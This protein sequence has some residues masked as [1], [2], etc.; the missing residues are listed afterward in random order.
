MR[1]S[2]NNKQMRER[3]ECDQR[4]HFGLRKFSVGVASV[5]LSTTFFMSSGSH[6][7]KADTSVTPETANSSSSN[8]DDDLQKKAV[9]LSSSSTDQASDSSSATQTSDATSTTASDTQKSAATSETATSD[10]QSS[11]S[12]TDTTTES[13]QKSDASSSSTAVS[14][15]QD[16]DAQKQ[17]A[18]VADG[19]AD[20][21]VKA[22]NANT[23]ATETLNTTKLDVQ[24]SGE[25][26]LATGV[27]VNLAATNDSSNVMGWSYSV[28]GSTVT[29]NSYSGDK[30]NVVIPTASDFRKAGVSSAASVNIS[31]SVMKSVVRAGAVSISISNTTSSEKVTASDADWSDALSTGSVTEGNNTLKT[32]DLNRLDT[33]NIT[34]MRYMFRRDVALTTLNIS[35]WNTANVTN[36]RSMFSFAG[37]YG[38]LKSIDVSGWNTGNVTDMYGMFY[39]ART[40]TNLDVSR[41]NTSKVTDMSWMFND[42]WSLTTL[43]VSKWDTRNVTDMSYMFQNDKLLT[44]LDVSNW[45]TSKVT[46]MTSMFSKMSSLTSLNVSGWNTANVT[47][48]FS[49][50]GGMSSLTSLDVSKWDTRNV[51]NMSYLFQG[52]K[53]LTTL[54]VS[55]WN[56]ANV[57][58][59]SSMFQY[60]SSLTSFDVSRWDTGKV[61]DM[62][63]VF[64]GMSS[65]T[66]LNVSGWNTSNVTNMRQMF[67][68]MSS[69][70]SLNVS[71]WNT[72]NVTNMSSMF[73]GDKSLTTLDVSKWYTGKVADMSWMFADAS[74]LTSLDVSGWNTSNVTNMSRVFSGMSSLTSLNVSGWKTGNVTNMSG[75][76]FG[77]TSLSE[78]SVKNWNTINVTDMSWM[79]SGASALTTLDVSDWLVNNVTSMYQMFG[80]TKSLKFLD[81]R[82]WNN[83]KL[84]DSKRY[85][86]AIT[87]SGVQTVFANGSQFDPTMLGMDAPSPVLIIV[88]NDTQKAAISRSFYDVSATVNGANTSRI[89]TPQIL[90]TAQ[91]TSQV[92]TDKQTVSDYLANN[93]NGAAY[94]LVNGYYTSMNLASVPTT[95]EATNLGPSAQALHVL[96]GL[97]KL[98]GSNGKQLNSIT[99]AG[100]YTTPLQVVTGTYNAQAVV[101]D[102]TFTVGNDG[103]I[104][105]NSYVGSGMDVKI[106]TLDDFKKAN[107]NGINDSSTVS[108]SAS[109]MKSLVTNGATSIKISDT[110]PNQKVVASGDNW[111]LALSSSN[112]VPV[113]YNSTLKSV[114]LSRLDTSNV[115]S[116]YK[117]FAYDNALTDV[118][119]SGWDTSKVTDFSGMFRYD[120]ALTNITGIE[121]I[122]TSSVKSMIGMFAGTSL[123]SLDLHK[124]NTS[125]VTFMLEM[126]AEMSNLSTLNLAGWNLSNV[127]A[128][129]YMFQRDTSL[130]SLDLSNWNLSSLSDANGMFEGMTN[131][132]SLKL[133]GWDFSNLIKASSN[134]TPAET[135]NS[136][137][138]EGGLTSLTDLSLSGAKFGLT[139]YRNLFAPAFSGLSALKNLDLSNL[140]DQVTDLHYAFYNEGS[141]TGMKL[142][143][144]NV[145]DWD[146]TQVTD[147]EYAFEDLD[148]P[149][150]DVSTW[151][152]SGNKDFKGMFLGSKASTINLPQNVNGDM[153]AMLQNT[154]NL[155]E[156]GGVNNVQKPT[157]LQGTFA[158]TGL[159]S[160]DLSS[161]DT[162]DVISMT[163]TFWDTT[164][165]KSL[166]IANWDTRKVT[167]MNSMFQ[168][169]GLTTI[170]ISGQNFVLPSG[171]DATTGMFTN[172][173]PVLVVV[174]DATE[175]AKISSQLSTLNA[176]VNDP[177][178]AFSLDAMS[179]N[180]GVRTPQLLTTEEYKEQVAKDLKTVQK[181]MNNPNQT[182]N[183]FA[184]KYYNLFDLGTVV[185]TPDN[186]DFGPKAQALRTLAGLCNTRYSYTDSDGKYYKTFTPDSDYTDMGSFTTGSFTPVSGSFN[187]K[188][189][190]DTKGN[191]QLISYVGSDMNVVI[192][193]A[194]DFVNA[195]I[196]TGSI[197]V[198]FEMDNTKPVYIDASSLREA[199]GK[200]ATS[201]TISNTDPSQTIIAR[202]SDWSGVF[203][204]KNASTKDASGN[205]KLDYNPSLKVLD[206]S[207][208]QTYNITD[209]RSMF[210]GANIEKLDLSGWNTKK[211]TYFSNMFEFAHIKD[212]NLDNL[213]TKTATEMTSMLRGMDQLKTLSVKGWDL[214]GI[215]SLAGLF[216][217]DTALESLD[218]STWNTS[219]A[220]AMNHMFAND[221]SLTYLNLGGAFDTSKATNMTAMFQNLTNLK[222]LDLSNFNT[223]KVSNM[224]NMFLGSNALNTLNISGDNF[225]INDG[226]NVTKMF[227][228]RSNAPILIVTKDA[229]AKTK[230]MSDSYNK[231]S[232]NDLTFTVNGTQKGN[233]QILTK[234]EYKAQ[235]TSDLETLNK[236]L[237]AN[238]DLN[239]GFATT[240]N[241]DNALTSVPT[242]P[243][244]SDFGPNAQAL[245]A[246]ATALKDVP[247]AGTKVASAQPAANP[248]LMMFVATNSTP[249]QS[250]TG[251][252]VPDK[253]YSLSEL[254]TGSFTYL[255][256][257]DQT[258]KYGDTVSA[259]TADM[260][261]NLPTGYVV[262]GWTSDGAPTTDSVTTDSNR[263]AYLT[264]S[265]GNQ[266]YK[267]PVYYAVH[268]TSEK[269]TVTTTDNVIYT[270]GDDSKLADFLQNIPAD[271]KVSDDSTYAKTDSVS[272]GSGNI[273]VTFGDGSTKT[274]TPKYLVVKAKTG[275]P[276]EQSGSTID[277]SKYVEVPTAP[278]G[279]NV[280]VTWKDSNKPDSNNV[281]TQNV[282]SVVTWTDDSGKTL[283]TKEVPVTVTVA[284]KSLAEQ[285]KDDF[286]VTNPVTYDYKE[287]PTIDAV[288]LEFDDDAD[289]DT[290]TDSIDSYV[291]KGEKPDTSVPNVQGKKATITINFS[292]GSS[293]DKE[294]VYNVRPTT[295]SKVEK[296]GIE[297]GKPVYDYGHELTS[298]D[299]ATALKNLPSDAKVVD[300]HEKPDTTNIG[301]G[302]NA[303]ATV[304]FGDGT[305][306][307]V[308][309][310]Y[311]VRS[312]SEHNNVQE[313]NHIYKVGEQP[314]LDDLL[315]NI[316]SDQQGV[317]QDLGTADSVGEKT[318]SITVTFGDGSQKT[319]SVKYL[320]VDATS[321]VDSATVGDNI[322]SDKYV[323][324][325]TPE[326]GTVTT[327]WKGG[328]A[329][330]S[331]TP[332]TTQHTVTVNWYG[333]DHQLLATKDV[334][335]DVTVLSMADKYG[336]DISISDKSYAY[337]GNVADIK[338][339][340]L[341]IAGDDDKKSTISGNIT[342]I[343]WT[344]TKPDS[345]KA[346]DKGETSVTITFKDNSTSTVKFNYTIG[347]SLESKAED[348]GVDV[349]DQTY[350][351]NQELNDT[352]DA[353]G[354]VT[355][356][357]NDAQVKWVN[358]PDTKVAGK[359][360]GS[361]EVTFGDGNKK[362]YSFNY[363]VQSTPDINNVQNNAHIYVVGATPT[364]SD[365]LT[366]LGDATV[367]EQSYTSGTANVGSYTGTVTL[368]FGNGQTKEY[369]VNYLVV[370]AK[371]DVDA[372][373]LNQNID[374]KNYVEVPTV[375]EGQT[376]EVAWD[377][378]NT[379][380]NDVSSTTPQNVTAVVTW[381]DADGKVMATANVP[382]K[383]VVASAADEYQADIKVNDKQYAYKEANPSVGKDDL[384]IT[385]DADTVK[386]H[387]TSIDWKDNSSKPDTNVAGKTGTTK[388][389]ITFD[390]GSTLD[391]DVN[392]TIGASQSDKASDYGVTTKNGEYTLNQ[393]L[394]N[395]DAKDL[396]NNLP[397]DASVVWGDM[398]DTST[399]GVDRPATVKITF[400]DGKT[401]V[402]NVKYT[403]KSSSQANNVVATDNV[404]YVV[405]DTASKEDFLK[406]V[407]SD[408]TVSGDTFDTTAVGEHTAKLTVTFGDQSTKQYDV[409][410]LVVKAKDSV[411]AVRPGVNA[412]PSNYVD[413]PATTDNSTVEVS[414]QTAPD[415]SESSKTA[416]S[417]TALVTWKGQDGTVLATKEVPVNVLVQNMADQYGDSISVNDKTYEYK[418]TN[419]D[420]TNSDLAASSDVLGNVKSIEWPEDATKPDTSV[421][422]ATGSSKVKI[423]F[424]DGSSVVKNF[425]YTVGH[426][427]AADIDD[428][429]IES[430]IA[431]YNLNQTLT[432]ADAKAQLKNL[433][434]DATVAW[435]TQPDT[436]K[437]GTFNAN[438]T[439][440]FGDQQTATV[441]VQYKV[442]SSADANNITSKDAIFT[443][444]EKGTKDSVLSDIPGDATVTGDTFDTATVGEKSAT[445]HV[446][447]GDNTSKDYT[448]KYLVV[449]AK[450]DVPASRPGQEVNASSYVDVPTLTDGTNVTVDWKGNGPDI[451]KSSKDPQTAT[452]VVT[453]TDK[454]GKTIATKDVTVNV[455][456]ASAADQYGSQVSVN[457][458]TYAYKGT[459]DDL[460]TGDLNT[461]DAIKGE[462]SKVEWNGDKPSTDTP[463]RNGSVQAKITFKDGSSVVKNVNYYVGKSTADNAS[464]Y[465]LTT[466]KGNYTLNQTIPADE[467]TKRVS[468][469]PS[470]AKAEWVTEPDTSST[471][472]RTAKVKITFGDES[473]LEKDVEYTVA[474]TSTE[475][476]V[477]ENGPQIY[478]VGEQPKS[479]DFLSDLPEDA[480]VT[481]EEYSATT[482]VASGTAKITVKFGDNST[483]VYN[484]DFLVVQAKD[485][486]PAVRVGSDIVASNYV[487][488]PSDA[489]GVTVAWKTGNEPDKTKSGKTA[490]QATAVVTWVKDG[491]TV[492][493]EVPVNVLVQNMADQYGD[494]ITVNDKSYDYK[495]ED[496]SVKKND[497]KSSDKDALT[498]VDSI[499][500]AEGATQPDTSKAKSQ[501]DTTVTIKFSDGS[502]VDKPVHYTV[503]ESKA[504][505]M[506]DYDISS[507]IAT[508]KVNQVLTA[509]DAK[510]QMV[511]LPD[512]ASVA[513]TNTP[514][515]SAAGTYN[516]NVTITFGDGET[517][518][519]LVSYKVQSSKDANNI[520]A[521]NNVIFTVGEKATKNSFL[522]SIPSDATV[523]GDNF[524]TNDLGEQSATIHVQFGDGSST[525]YDVKYMVVKPTED[526]PSARPGQ[527]IAA[528]KYVDVPELSDGT[529]AT[530]TW[531]GDGPD[532]NNPSTTPQDATAVVTW[533]D[534]SGKQLATKEVPV[535]VTVISAANEYG[536]KFS[537][538]EQT[539]DYKGS[540]RGLTKDDLTATDAIKGEVSKIEW[541]ADA[542]STDTPDHH[543]S[544]SAKVTF[545]DGS[546]VVKN[547]NYYVGKSK[548]SDEANYN[549]TTADGNYTLNQQLTDNDAKTLVTNLPSDA[550]VAW[551]NKPDTSAPVQGKEATVVIT[552]GDGNT[553]T[554]TVHYNVKSSSTNN[555]I[556]TNDNVI[557]V[558]GDAAK[559]SDFLND[560]PTDATVTG[561]DFDTTTVGA[562]TATL[563]VK[564]GDDSTKDYTVNYLVVKANENVP[565]ARLNDTI[566][567][568]NYV[569]VPTPSDSSKVTVTWK[570]APDATK[571]ST[572][573]QDAVAT[574][575]WTKDGKTLATKDVDVKVLVASEADQYGADITV[576]DKAYE[577]KQTDTSVKNADLKSDNT[578]AL[579][580]VKSIDW[581][582]DATK[583]DTTQAKTSGDTKVT[584]TFAD[585]SSI[586]KPVHYTVAASKAEDIDDYDVDTTIGEYKLNHVLTSEDAKS[587]VT[588]LPN[589]ATVAWVGQPDTSNTGTFTA[590]ITITFGDGNSVTKKVQYKVKSS[591]DANNITTNDAIYTVNAKATKDDVMSNIPGDATVTGDT[592]DTSTVGEHSATLHVVFGDNSTKDYTVKYVVV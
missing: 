476:T 151:N 173:T 12:S 524:N 517:A 394:T 13:S 92:T 170:N 378:N 15:S 150:I 592:F 107:V 335:V 169:T 249:S 474:S 308:S 62:S 286:S 359:G 199:V 350:T 32:V 172:T 314:Q 125:N 34:S 538:N 554:K 82:S 413:V 529:K 197:Y 389:T 266:T 311:S 346:G 547:V 256:T 355:D 202:D 14:A 451:N 296:Y 337:K 589:D 373:R 338:D 181:I 264:V 114:N 555:N 274:Y 551:G 323:S 176:K 385:G 5:L 449:N 211:V 9:T 288:D 63:S 242:T 481:G 103:N 546:S 233:S 583:P 375:S 183:S 480:E 567:A 315:K 75:I 64:Y 89:T 500:W 418:A 7:V 376:V 479:S 429:D 552:F 194:T 163:Q 307:Y 161:W 106:P 180:V 341:T 520:T 416:K 239:N 184:T 354:V 298:D 145:S 139:S 348:Y 455:L 131:L 78:I 464:T 284:Q 259:P 278:A 408:A 251:V 117:M 450:D 105:L 388:V 325:P 556:T 322:T 400:G 578:D 118:N 370:Q 196:I 390:D 18:K 45:N 306:G 244:T 121:D 548:A 21:D 582:K 260:I 367:T 162:S 430:S 70:T 44:T 496:T 345:N 56:T 37:V 499:T 119:I 50:F 358:K 539:Y 272:A 152:M 477:V 342:G 222:S 55:K 6:H 492:T 540:V 409:K 175:K 156:L 213:V 57:T 108:I 49:M 356:L 39:G 576:N 238:D 138:G 290:I 513:W 268:S 40:L 276:A 134:S 495:A 265:L 523:T 485:N 391:K 462:V 472:T 85:A 353:A 503:G 293:V 574:V 504:E 321:N 432:S 83:N 463:N 502:S 369:T 158:G 579:A 253:N 201:I 563:H 580:A 270:V 112:E 506:D 383:V 4:Q 535:K 287:E 333:S 167:T 444:G 329:P 305:R 216:Q 190:S 393:K 33:K 553:V 397:S 343:A 193:T 154:S 279:T 304:Q 22:A 310:T 428:Y 48:M 281:S 470:D 261:A 47:S 572:T 326:E 300:W 237:G 135:L 280:T 240:Y 456:I 30:A 319:Y 160:L 587:Q 434:N 544:V 243:D 531:K 31:A 41:W 549:I 195:G 80:D 425:N 79:F 189:Y 439:I 20:I 404:I 458:Q 467:A 365:F 246:V 558:A 207:R 94:D 402:E 443:V 247:T 129:S 328:V 468:N 147:A 61:T 426:S 84:G 226:T 255:I 471:G 77:T 179:T 2:K 171:T 525:D 380:K 545:T 441:M 228:Y 521:H 230:I 366:N 374:V 144:L 488:V 185:T 155:T 412:D 19:D 289:Q 97:T 331:A 60:L 536:D 116:M 68:K 165:L 387:I 508:Y 263:T 417:A 344:S 224:T 98:T 188:F 148:V 368:Q 339:S 303:S 501:G 223:N 526:A 27:L 174:K 1:Y 234:D 484:E 87:G 459:V 313:Y 497:L 498:G 446:V 72:S 91:Y 445:L 168:H 351:L 510:N 571:S 437:T 381:K 283:A 516:A 115:K 248:L 349:E 96:A 407:P 568:S 405:D 54:D 36:M 149:T 482:G 507:T 371:D 297:D 267:V 232:L 317:T 414:W 436:S 392:Y 532:K 136:F 454:D 277:A 461:T 396:V 483:K 206:L 250:Y 73:N 81:L 99:A 372:V 469:L 192:P 205:E 153:S 291:W 133:N 509:E 157:S 123:T 90:T 93:K 23:A 38:D 542:P 128:L 447:F 102:W 209:M 203:G 586:D 186:S 559:A 438:V 159:S 431:E 198:K 111:N 435:T 235:V 309:F 269:N 208:L 141:Q 421:A 67:S 258:Y 347:P 560:V 292:D 35:S 104:T 528:S 143:S 110:N 577:Y 126:F 302:H 386:G 460:T 28:N 515:T 584:I 324:V 219:N 519:M 512:D 379:P 487:S 262:N 177:Y 71:G 124:W 543:G 340:D 564:F 591:A 395:D 271:A 215:N 182:Y 410:Y 411:P 505:Y 537:V 327:E 364:A 146:T 478:A 423:N 514:N 299:Y 316:P 419:L 473:T 95:T 486:V 527:D 320:V 318:A 285:Y 29:L 10:A 46:D 257:N 382:V 43:D 453:W 282:T 403:V 427:K 74:S 53:L 178:R 398:P 58:D 457:D 275:M 273:V 493:K 420:V 575:T 573:A 357:P 465:N 52:D 511:N 588:N 294:V 210:R 25:N 142:D 65:L 384:T 541:N 101:M 361:V 401:V 494:S 100:N 120:G 466:T 422:G 489:T 227:G 406:N 569:S 360:T 452:A 415:T 362:T 130:T 86:R 562:K 433:P 166:N 42:S 16:T 11:T 214:T 332:G 191:P 522:D 225:T 88:D 245:H 550:T 566:D 122:N 295:A 59:M 590:S 137:F 530:V 218:L 301:T 557:Y 204:T 132:A 217:N 69:L 212:M 164:K 534:A 475:N 229:T 140:K 490:Q 220:T 312:T 561:A 424:T 399:P 26:A 200:G 113:T 241:A 330:S 231:N 440:T 24:K 51:T 585:G 252:V 187:W 570:T 17:T 254:A 221:N 8:S 66:S 377:T 336:K 334:D 442:K 3:K 76:F 518:T 363:T 127:S 352:T 533:T 491:K 236:T 109:V 448:V 581:A 565:A